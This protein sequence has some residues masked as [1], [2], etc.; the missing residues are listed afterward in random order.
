M[1]SEISFDQEEQALRFNK[2]TSY[3][4]AP[5]RKIPSISLYVREI[6]RA[7]R[8]HVKQKFEA[9]YGSPNNRRW[10]EQKFRE[11]VKA[12][13]TEFGTNAVIK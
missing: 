9:V 7:F 10:T 8:K 4:P 6:L 12:F 3:V 1:Q 11:K 5:K 13:F 2:P